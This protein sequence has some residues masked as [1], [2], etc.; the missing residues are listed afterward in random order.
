MIFLFINFEIV[1]GSITPAHTT[2]FY[3]GPYGDSVDGSKIYSGIFVYD[4]AYRVGK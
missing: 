2:K 4:V 1:S 3:S